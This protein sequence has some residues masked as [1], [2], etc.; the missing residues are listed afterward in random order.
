VESRRAILTYHSLD[1]S[2]SVVSVPP[3][4][5]A[6]QMA[7]LAASG[8][9]VAPLAGLLAAPP[10]AVA[11][12]FDD[13]FDNFADFGAPI[14]AR[15]GFPATVFVVSGHCGGFNDWGSQPAGIPRLRLLEWS[16]IRELTRAGFE[17][18]AHTVNHPNL[19]ELD[20]ARA[21]EEILGSKQ[22]IEEA[23]GQPVRC[24]AYPY[25][26]MPEAARRMVA[27]HF[28]AGCSTCMGWITP[29]SR[30]EALERLD[31]YYLSSTYLF[32][33]LFGGPA[34]GYLALRRA[35]RAFNTSGRLYD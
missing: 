4:L 23:I 15:H 21:R 2:G 12:T 35:L 31:A 25:G 1:D 16:R 34:R 6:R 30:A 18:G 20:D 33:R 29:G 10:P 19:A 5:F 27:E 22:R 17:F 11:L 28:A 13:G 7:A 8:V 3:H 26:A 24:F 32:R 9:K 14:L